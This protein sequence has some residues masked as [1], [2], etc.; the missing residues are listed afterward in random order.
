MRRKTLAA[1]CGL[2]AAASIGLSACS[3]SGG[4]GSSPASVTLTVIGWKGGAAE[5]ANMT[6]IN[7]AF[8][9]S[10]PNIKIDYTFVDSSEYDT[11]LNSELL[12]GGAQDVV[13]ANTTDAPRWAKSGYLEDLSRQPWVADLSAPDKPLSV[14]NGKVY[15][16]PNELTGIG[17]F[18]NLQ[19]LKAAGISAPP[20]TWPELLSDLQTL[21]KDG[22]P[23]LALPDQSGWTVFEAINASAADSVYAHDPT[24]DSQLTSG[25]ASFTTTSGWRSAMQQVVGLGSQGLINYS[26]Q[27]GVNEWGQGLQNFEAGDDAFLLQGSWAMDELSTAVGPSN[28]ALS[29]WPGGQAGA[30]PVATTAVGTMWTINARTSHLQAAEEYLDYWSTAQAMTPYL[31]A[32]ASVSPFSNV[33]SPKIAGAASFLSAVGSGH[34]WVL[35]ENGWA[36]GQ[37]QTDLGNADQ[38]LLLGKSDVAQ[39]L[40]SYN[41]IVKKDVG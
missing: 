4:S 32:E 12:G 31:T 1:F 3:S 5:P 11:K 16:E 10:H 40:S 17:L 37:S 30:Q 34:F 33:P 24:W 20:A 15:A 21:K 26:A 29:P 19:V 9:A 6:E 28:L 25:S 23:G 7:N 2:A 13:M 41:S 22:K 35:P 38:G 27:L 36:G 8:E 39:T 14:V 18:S